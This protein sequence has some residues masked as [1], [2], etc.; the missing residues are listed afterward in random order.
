[1]AVVRPHPP[2]QTTQRAPYWKSLPPEVLDGR[3]AALGLHLNRPDF[4]VLC[5]SCGYALEPSGDVM[6]KHLWEKHHV[7]AECRAGLNTFVRSLGLRDPNNLAIRR[8]GCTP[9]P[10]LSVQPGAACGLCPFK[11]TSLELL[12]HHMSMEHRHKS[13]GQTSVRVQVRSCVGLLHRELV[14]NYSGETN[15]H[16]F[17]RHDWKFAYCSS[18]ACL[19][20]WRKST[21]ES[22]VP[23]VMRSYRQIAVATLEKHLPALMHPFDAHTPRGYDAFY[24]CLVSRRGLSQPLMPTCKRSR[25]PSQRSCSQVL[26]DGSSRTVVSGMT[27]SCWGRAILSKPPLTI[28]TTIPKSPTYLLATFPAHQRKCSNMMR[29]IM[30]RIGLL[31]SRRMIQTRSS[32]APVQGK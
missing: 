5:V 22:P 31:A 25:Q 15:K 8:D 12:K 3:L 10:Y 29:R 23:L 11:T 28:V 6:S 2:P 21:M 19:R 16:L 4:A 9:H 24:G 30:A 1:M 26:Y 13:D 20:C 7:P 17:T 32:P 18:D 27:F 14:E